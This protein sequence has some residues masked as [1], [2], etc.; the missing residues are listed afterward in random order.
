MSEVCLY[1]YHG[2][3]I[4]FSISSDIECVRIRDHESNSQKRNGN[5]VGNIQWN[6]I[7][8]GFLYWKTWCNE[9]RYNNELDFREEATRR[10]V[11]IK[12]LETISNS[13]LS[14]GRIEEECVENLIGTPCFAS[15]I[16]LFLYK[17]SSKRRAAFYI[18]VCKQKDRI[19]WQ[20]HN[21]NFKI[22]TSTYYLK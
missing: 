6:D 2:D 8:M 18:L 5:S 12:F 14:T 21:A 1:I 3:A 10:P 22:F 9:W 15:F 13:I 17:L 11:Y 16:M 20:R 19:L 7:G 4:K